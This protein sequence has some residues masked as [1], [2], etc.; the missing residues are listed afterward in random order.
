MAKQTSPQ[1]RKVAISVPLIHIDPIPVVAARAAACPD[2]Q[3][4]RLDGCSR[5]RFPEHAKTI[6]S[7]PNPR[8]ALFLL[9]GIYIPLITLQYRTHQFDLT[10]ST[11]IRQQSHL[12]TRVIHQHIQICPHLYECLC[13]IVILV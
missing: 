10:M 2:S 8:S 3:R 11:R 1:E 4:G 7:P 13:D 12:I 6:T 5:R 9:R